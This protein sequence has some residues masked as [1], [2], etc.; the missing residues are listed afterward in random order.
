MPADSPA[1][2]QTWARIWHSQPQKAAAARTRLHTKQPATTGKA[3]GSPQLKA[4][5]SLM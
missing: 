3:R 4:Q 5:F 1:Q 2:P